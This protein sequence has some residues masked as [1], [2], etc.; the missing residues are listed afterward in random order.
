MTNPFHEPAESGDSD[1]SVW[2]DLVRRLEADPTDPRSPATPGSPTPE[3][4]GTPG[5]PDASSVPAPRPVDP[6]LFR[7]HPALT[8]PRDY[9]APEDTDD[10]EFIPE[11]P[12][13]LGSG[14]PLLNLAWVCAAGAPIALV[15]LTIFWRRAPAPLWVGLVAIAVAAAIF[16]FARLPRHRHDGDDGARV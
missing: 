2:E 16:L 11:D 6:Q 8:G 5:A 13:A 14:N 1:D 15:L 9:E 3:N 10:G 12:P 4:P 7:M